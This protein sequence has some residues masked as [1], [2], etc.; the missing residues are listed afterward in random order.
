MNKTYKFPRPL[1]NS[2]HGNSQVP[3]AMSSDLA[4]SPMQRNRTNTGTN[5]QVSGSR[6]PA[7]KIVQSK[8]TQSGQKVASSS[9]V[10]KI[11]LRNQRLLE[12][13]LNQM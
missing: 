9:E 6:S 4:G 11:Q 13:N 2:Q 7:G 3:R 1:L 5:L 10:A 8:L 12:D